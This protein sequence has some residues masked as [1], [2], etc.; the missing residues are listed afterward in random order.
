MHHK[1]QRRL[2]KFIEDRFDH[3]KSRKWQNRDFE[4]LSFQVKRSTKVLLSVATLKR[5]FGKVQVSEGYT[6]QR[7]TFEALKLYADYD[8]QNDAHNA[9][10]KIVRRIVWVAVGLTF[11]VGCYWLLHGRLTSEYVS[12]KLTL[13]RLE[14]KCPSTAYFNIEVPESSD[15][16]KIDFG[17]GEINQDVKEGLHDLTHFYAYPGRFE[18]TLKY[19]E[20]SIC[21]PVPVYIV[22][23][24]WQA[25]AHYYETMVER[26]HPIPVEENLSDN[27]FRVSPGRL[28]SMGLDTTKIVV[29]RL[30]NYEKTD[31]SADTF[32]Y[33]TRLR[34]DTFWPGVRCYSVIISIQGTRGKVEFKLV[35]EGCSGYSQVIIGNEILDT[36]D[37]PTALVLNMKKWSDIE[38]RN[39]NKYVELYI[40]G[41]LLFNHRYEASLGQLFGTSVIFHGSGTVENVIL[42]TNS[43]AVFK[44][45]F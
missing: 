38:I 31:K 2:I 32:N 27:Q 37:N 16:V 30:D 34:N 1:D 25:F 14:G 21:N 23:E 42:T 20:K 5:F 28:S 22:T 17:D 40:N 29:V 43:E 7:S 41:E 6:P 10:M 36:T 11:I 44:T 33:K 35:A 39:H 19:Q 4:A 45:Y 12:G 3:G 18:A 8:T 24:G 26:Y 9:K 15:T 13:K